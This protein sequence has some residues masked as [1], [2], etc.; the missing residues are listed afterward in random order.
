M[1]RFVPLHIISGYSFLQSGLTINRIVSNVQK[2][3]Y[4]GA[5]ITDNL[6][7]H[8]Y[9]TFEHGIKSLNKK[10]ILGLSFTVEGTNIST[11]IQNEDGYKNLLYVHNC[12]SKKGITFASLKNHTSGLI[13][14]VESWSGSFLENFTK[15]KEHFNKYLL[16]IYNLFPNN[17][18]LGVQ[19]LCKEDVKFANEIRKF[20]DEFT[21]QT[22][23]FPTIKYA[24]KEDAIVLKIVDA[25]AKQKTLDVKKESGNECFFTFDDYKKIYTAK[26]IE[27]TVKVANSTSFTLE[28]KR[29]K[30][31]NLSSNPD[32][33]LKELVYASLKKKNL[34]NDKYLKQADYELSVISKMGFSNYFLL[35]QDYVNYAKNNDILVGPG[36]GSAAGSLIGYLLNIT[37]VDPHDFDLQFERFLNPSRQTMPDIDVDFVDT[38]RNLMVKYMKEK[39]GYDRVS[40]IISFQTIKAKQALSD[41]QRVYQYPEHHIVLIKKQ[42]S[43]K[44]LSLSNAYKTIPSFKELIDSDNYF[45]EIVSLANKIEGL[46]RQTGLHAAGIIVNNEPL[47]NVMPVIKDDEGNL[48]TGYDAIYLEEQGFLKMDFLALSNLRTVENC[49]KLINAKHH[50]NLKADTLPYDDEQ[51]IKLISEGKTSGIFQVETATM[52]KSIRMLKPKSFNDIV[53]LLA[54]GRP[55]TMQ[56][57]SDY[58]K[59]RDGQKKLTYLSKDIESIL[60][61]TYGVI[62]YQEQVN[63]IAL[64]VAG[65]SAS[66]ADLFRRAISKKDKNKIQSSKQDFVNGAIKNGYSKK[67]AE[68]IF[69]KI[70][71]FAGYGFNKSHSVVYAIL[72]GRMA[73]LKAHYPLEFYSCILDSSS[74]KDDKFP[75]YVSEIKSFGLNMER[76]DVNKSQMNFL[77]N[78][79][80]LIMPLTCIK[81]IFVESVI[82]I[83]KERNENGAF[84]DFFEFN[85]RM[86]K[87]SLGESQIIKLID[88]GSFDSIYP[89]RKTLLTA[90]KSAI[91]YAELNY[92][93][94]GQQ[95]LS[96]DL[97]SKPKILEMKD[98]LMENIEKEYD[99]LG[100]T[101]G[102]SP[103]TLIKPRLDDIGC[104]NIN[105][106]EENENVKIAGVIRYKK[107]IKTKKGANMAFIKISDDTG[108]IEVT[109]FPTVYANCVSFLEKNNIIV[110]DGKMEI[111]EEAGNSFIANEVFEESAI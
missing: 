27:N 88:A 57:I 101:L 17:F 51:A 100:V 83:I 75:D 79:S 8:S 39:Y 33:E 37:E 82:N 66:E 69:E 86:F 1:N 43:N 47:E 61:S 6:S 50:L 111:D 22:I 55:A 106:L 73:Y 46:P 56:F 110:I 68:N 96:F 3:D 54:L 2:F 48:V 49:V 30:I 97:I 104:I 13:A 19:V 77:I 44:D 60:S 35:T 64:K 92:D 18:Y 59:G 98:N 63:S 7:M 5:G 70:L 32:E 94:N 102:T 58:Q 20:A 4:Y 29:G 99:V 25:I 71:N 42:L 78:D 80:S 31:I 10:P 34:F 72:A 65:Y 62:V 76:P 14:I 15:N 85:Q 38:K 109:I 84:K 26:E 108:E 89:S 9:P 74:S 90:L 107:V 21:Y 81:G 40:S 105:E 23:A 36:R 103:I 24:K 93:K 12:L 87:Y 16:D 11:F 53:A 67:D 45:K 52:K 91:Q 28:A 95:L 41:I